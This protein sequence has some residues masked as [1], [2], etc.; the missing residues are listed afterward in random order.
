MDERRT[1]AIL[2]WTIGGVVTTMFVLS[3]LAMSSMPTAAEFSASRLVRSASLSVP[4]ASIS[5]AGSKLA[6]A[7][8]QG[9]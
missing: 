2:G 6:S 7:A 1:L 9:G 3:G 8:D 5:P 4:T